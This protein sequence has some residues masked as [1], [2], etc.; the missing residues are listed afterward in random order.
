MYENKWIL[1]YVTNMSEVD[2]KTF[3]YYILVFF[4]IKT[5]FCSA[6]FISSYKEVNQKIK[7]KLF[8]VR[9]GF[10]QVRQSSALRHQI[11]WV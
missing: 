6:A 10:E 4:L 8:L 5:L 11:I 9:L 1:K 2:F 3:F 7:L